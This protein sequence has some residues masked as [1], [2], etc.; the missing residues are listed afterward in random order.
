MERSG[1]GRRGL[2]A[3]G[4]AVDD[5]NLLAGAGQLAGDAGPDDSG[6]DD[7]DVGPAPAPARRARAG[8]G[9]MAGGVERR[10]PPHSG[11]SSARPRGASA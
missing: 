9:T 11:F 1:V 5:E 7:Q 6:P 10:C 2:L 8:R 4:V 3:D